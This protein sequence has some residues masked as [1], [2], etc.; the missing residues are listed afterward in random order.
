MSKDIL[1]D[2]QPESSEEAPEKNEKKKLSKEERRQ[3]EMSNLN[4]ALASG[5]LTT[6]ISKVASIL[7]RFEETRNS[8]MALKIKYWEIFEGFTG[9]F[10]D[11]SQMFKLT[12]DTSI[13]R[14]RAKIQNEYKLYQANDR[15]KAYR[16][17]KEELEKEIQLSTK[18]GTPSIT[19]YTDESGKSNAD[20]YMIIGGLWILESDRVAS[21][22]RHFAEWRSERKNERNM[23]KE[24]HFTEMRGGQLQHYKDFFSEMISMSD[25]LSLKAVVFDRTSSKFKSIDEMIYALYYQHVH[26]GVQHEVNSGRITLPRTVNFWK[27]QEIGAD[28]LFMNELEQHL[29]THFEGYFK[30]NLT[31]NTFSA[32]D[33]KWSTLIQL[34]DL[35]TGCINRAINSPKDVVKNHKD[36]FAEFVFD[37]LN[38]DLSDLK[39]QEQDMAMI[40]YI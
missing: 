17:D 32:I 31:L 29:V 40:H 4:N 15:I 16:N 24:F 23:P 7:N 14:A 34:A 3:K 10:V 38:L 36:E 26:H 33:S 35:Y 39:N 18:P 8:D 1:R 11:V 20:K 21:L 6:L 5:N 12:R 9:N 27:D 37:I 19:L 22:H 28:N 25:M 2:L 30:K 13:S